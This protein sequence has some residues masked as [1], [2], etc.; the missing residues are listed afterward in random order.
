MRRLIPA[1]FANGWTYL[2]LIVL[3][4]PLL[5]LSGDFFLFSFAALITALVLIVF[6]CA[7]LHAQR[8][9]KKH[10][11]TL[12][13][14][15]FFA[16]A[17]IWLNLHPINNM[18]GVVAQ[19][20]MPPGM[21]QATYGWPF[22]FAFTDSTAVDLMKFRLKP[23]SF[24]ERDG[25]AY[26]FGFGFIDLIVFML[27]NFC[28][29]RISEFLLAPLY[30]KRLSAPQNLAGSSSEVAG[31]VALRELKPIRAPLVFLV[32]QFVVVEILVF[33]VTDTVP[34]LLV[35][36][37]LFFALTV[38]AWLS[39]VRTRILVG[40][41]YIAL[42]WGHDY[43]DRVEFR[44]IDRS[45]LGTSKE[46]VPPNELRIFGA[47]SRVPRLTLPLSRFSVG[48][49]A[50]LVQLPELKLP[51]ADRERLAKLLP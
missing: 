39:I 34:Q 20:P 40:S 17:V 29:G 36:S 51:Q 37:L 50:W 9:S 38:A 44:E 32:A 7:S 23:N 41:E 22:A 33:I 16:G 3:A 10:L 25:N 48:D 43:L 26:V 15:T 6:S 2:T 14:Q 5:L 19:K 8:P 11:P 46:K 30:R 18:L 42:K 47:D 24:I 49:I 28:V 4:I 35:I 45:N 31:Q 21:Y 13:I 1:R 27:F 12:V